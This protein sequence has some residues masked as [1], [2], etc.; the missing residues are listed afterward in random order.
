[1]AKKEIEKTAFEAKKGDIVHLDNIYAIQGLG[2][3]SGTSWWKPAD[4]EE[5]EEDERTNRV[6]ITRDVKIEIKVKLG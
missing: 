3:R 6:V 1:M 4:D 5:G 2:P